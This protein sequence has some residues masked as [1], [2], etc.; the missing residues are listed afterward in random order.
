MIAATSLCRPLRQCTSSGNLLS[1]FSKITVMNDSRFAQDS[2]LFRQV[3]LNFNN[4]SFKLL[5]YYY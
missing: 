2:F 1:E 4:S 3:I 5:L